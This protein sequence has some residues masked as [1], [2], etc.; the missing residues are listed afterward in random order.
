MKRAVAILL[1]ALLLAA[2]AFGCGAPAAT[3][4]PAPHPF[5]TALTDFMAERGGQASAFLVDIDGEGTQGMLAIAD[6]IS[7][8][9]FF[10][11]DGQLRSE[12]T[13]T[14]HIATMNE[15]GRLV[16]ITSDENDNVSSNFVR[17]DINNRLVLEDAVAPS[18]LK[19]AGWWNEYPNDNEEILAMTI[20]A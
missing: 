19:P 15:Q 6:D 20:E 18:D 11:H 13:Q 2:L 17:V 4:E 9:I 3:E 12:R 1:A 5:A 10:I 14:F 7:C 8:V 16:V